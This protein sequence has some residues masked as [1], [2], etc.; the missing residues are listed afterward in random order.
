[1]H[2]LSGDHRFRRLNCTVENLVNLKVPIRIKKMLGLKRRQCMDVGRLNDVVGVH[3]RAGKLLGQ[4]QLLI[5]AVGSSQQR[6]GI[7]LAF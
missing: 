7:A 2:R 6:E 3:Y 5:R 4:V 1:M